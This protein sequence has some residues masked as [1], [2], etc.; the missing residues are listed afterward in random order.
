MTTIVLYVFV[1][2]AVA[3][4]LYALAALVFG[5][6]EGLPP[7]PPGTT[8]TVLPVSGVTAADVRAL[9]FQQV[10]RGYRPAEVDWALEQLAKEIESLRAQLGA[11]PPVDDKDGVQQGRAA[12]PGDDR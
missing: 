1:V 7:L 10:L 9:R 11:D 5:R 3:A 8:P 6:G 2:C 12:R 4:V